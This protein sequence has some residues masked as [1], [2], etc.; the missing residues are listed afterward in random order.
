[1]RFLFATAIFVVLMT[2][3]LGISLLVVFSNTSRH[4]EQAM[5]TDSTR[6]I[7]TRSYHQSPRVATNAYS[8]TWNQST[9]N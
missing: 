8:H 6:E 3:F 7:N 4:L 1:M 9:A 2:T 5:A